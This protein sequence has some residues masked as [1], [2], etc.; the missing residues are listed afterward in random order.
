MFLNLKNALYGLKQAPRALYERLSKF[1]LEKDF[2]MG[3]ID[4]TLFIKTKE[5]DMFLV[6]IYVWS[7]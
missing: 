4:T 5:N 7:Y 6:P 3:K 1:N 2:K